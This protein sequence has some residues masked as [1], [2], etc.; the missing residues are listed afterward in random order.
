MNKGQDG[1]TLNSGYL[2]EQQEAH[3]RIRTGITRAVESER[4]NLEMHRDSD[5]FDSKRLATSLEDIAFVVAGHLLFSMNF[6]SANGF[7]YARL[8]KVKSIAMA[9]TVQKN[10]PHQ[11]FK[12]HFKWLAGT[13]CRKHLSH[14]MM[15]RQVANPRILLFACGISYDRSAGAGKLNSLDTLIEQ[16]KSYMNIL[17]DK[18]TAL[19]PDVIFVERT[20]SR[21]AQ[22]LLRARRVGIVLNVK[23]EIL[24]RISRHTGAALLTSVD[25]VD[26]SRAEDV[27]GTCRSFLVKTVPVVP[28]EDETIAVSAASVPG[29]S[30]AVAT[31]AK[32]ETYLYLDGCDP[33]NG[34]TVLLTGP[35][36]PKLR[37]LKR[38]TRAVLSMTY[39]LLLEAH[40]LSDLDSHGS[41]F[42]FSL[43]HDHERLHRVAD[44]GALGPDSVPADYDVAAGTNNTTWYTT[45]TLRVR[46]SAS[47]NVRYHPCT[48]CKYF[49][50][51]AYSDEDV[52]F[53]NFL[54][55]EMSALLLKCQVRMRW[56]AYVQCGS[57]CSSSL[58]LSIEPKVQLPDGG[59]RADVQL[60]LGDG[61]DLVRRAAARESTADLRVATEPE[62]RERRGVIARQR[63]W[64]GWHARNADACAHDEAARPRRDER[65]GHAH[66]YLR[67][68][69]ARK[70]REYKPPRKRAREL[71]DNRVLAL[72]P[73]VQRHGDAVCPARQVRVQVLVRALPRDHVL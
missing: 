10:V 31:K 27:V 18:I 66:W 22:E 21:H 49:G 24:E 26:K 6:R 57:E 5:Q 70:Q 30:L 23:F 37:V 65:D 56:S 11:H 14:K 32:T 50:I 64:Y 44:S 51:Q 73:R 45:C 60:P 8:V 28:N 52:S 62:R 9:E 55:Q 40:V 42:S 43:A 35:S 53:G 33:L 68:A 38:L 59:P 7:N 4:C 63:D 20:V 39:R 41:T 29:T 67:S 48:G 58:S 72:V 61:H 69:T 3:D 34:C 15:A 19:E 46:E 36:K 25:H 54:G 12:F 71:A 17:V 13:L 47:T 2:R 1:L 16:E